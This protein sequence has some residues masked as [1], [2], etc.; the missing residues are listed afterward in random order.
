MRIATARRLND[1]LNVKAELEFVYKFAY[2]ATYGAAGAEHE[3]CHVFLGQ[4][5]SALHPNEHEIET[6]R[7]VSTSSLESEFAQSPERFTPWFKL[8]WHA[9]RTEHN[10]ALGKYVRL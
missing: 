4:I 9:L 7:F 8:E 6:T 1:E 3:L 2:Q 5:D 10:E